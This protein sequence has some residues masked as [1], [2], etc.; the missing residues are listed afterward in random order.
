VSLPHRDEPTFLAAS[1]SLGNLLRLSPVSVVL[2]VGVRPA[3]IV[4]D[5]ACVKVVAWVL[6]TTK[7]PSHHVPSPWDYSSCVLRHS[8]IGGVTS[9]S[10]LLAIAHRA[11]T[12]VT[13]VGPSFTNTLHQV[14]DPTLPGRR[15]PTSAIE[16]GAPNTPSGLLDWTHRFQGITAPTV[17]STEH[18]VRRRLSAKELGNVLDVPADVI[19]L[20]TFADLRAVAVPGIIL[21][22]LAARLP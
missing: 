20:L 6:P 17:F 11:P 12:T 10:F 9:G 13:W 7:Q 3:S 21:S 8:T 15:V 1:S 4:W 22:H 19:P 2:F 18:L 5:T 14:L 16:V